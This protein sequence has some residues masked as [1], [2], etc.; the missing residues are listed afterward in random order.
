MAAPAPSAPGPHEDQGVMSPTG[1]RRAID[2]RLEGET[3]GPRYDRHPAGN[4]MPNGVLSADVVR[5]E[6]MV[7]AS[8]G[9]ASLESA[10]WPPAMT[11]RTEDVGPPGTFSCDSGLR[12]ETSSV[13]AGNVG[14]TIPHLVARASTDNHP[15]GSQGGTAL[16]VPS[17]MSR[18][19]DYLRQASGQVETLTTT[20]TRS[21]GTDDASS[22]SI[23]VELVQ[24]EVRRQVEAALA[25][26]KGRIVVYLME[27]GP[28]Q[29]RKCFMRIVVYLM[30][31][32]PTQHRKCFMR[33]VV[34]LMEIGPLSQLK[35]FMRIVAY[36]MEIGPLSQ[37]K[38][39]MRIVAYLM[40]IGPLSQLKCF[41]RIVAYLM[42]I[43]PL[44]QL[45][46]FMR[47]VAYLME[48]GPL[49]QHM[50]FVRIV[51]Y[52]MEIGPPQ[53]L[54]HFVRI[55]VYLMEIG[56][57]QHLMHFVRIVVYL[58]EIGPLSLMHLVRIVVYLMEIGPTQHLMH[59]LRIVVYLMVVNQFR[60]CLG[61]MMVLVHRGAKLVPG[62]EVQED[63]ASLG[64]GQ[65]M[66]MLVVMVPSDLP[67]RVRRQVVVEELWVRGSEQQPGDVAPAA[68]SSPSPMDIVLTGIGQL[69]QMLLKK[70]D[71]LDVDKASPNFPMLPDYTPESGAIDFQDWLYLVEQQVS[72]MAA[73]A[74]EWWKQ[75]MGSALEAYQEY[76]ALSPIKRLGVKARLSE[77]LQDGKYQKL[78]KKVAALLLAALPTGVRD[79]LV[80]YRVQGTHQILFRLMAVY[81]PGGAQDRAQLL[82]QLEVSESPGTATDA[83]VALRRWYRLYQRALD[84][85]VSLP[86]ESVQVKSLGVLTKKVAE[87]N[88]DFR[89]K[90]SLAKAELQI[91]TRPTSENVLKYFQ[92]LLAECEQLGATG[93]KATPSQASEA[94]GPKLKGMQQQPSDAGNTTQR[95]KAKASPPP[96]N[97]TKPCSWFTT[98]DGCRNGKNCSFRHSWEGLQRAERCLLCGSTKHRARDCPTKKVSP[99]DKPAPKPRLAKQQAAAATP[100]TGAAS[101]EGPS[102]SSGPS[103]PAGDATREQPSSLTPSTSNKID[104]E[105]VAAMLSETNKML[106]ALTSTQAQ[107]SGTGS[108][109]SAPSDPLGV[110]QRQLEDLRRLRMLVV[111][112]GEG[113]Q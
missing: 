111:L 36:L 53:H 70:G 81:Q 9:A 5:R 90:V 101:S 54:M 112:S 17:W 72:A 37:L 34:Y 44:S 11:S 74:G 51:V 21:V 2:S 91:D 65:G 80:A 82:K 35:C 56:P 20:L 73:S 83:V 93:R 46:C 15:G 41:M 1:A 104:T 97:P 68:P 113:W 23:P 45:K 12:Q 66:C 13:S 38:C 33:I 42:E 47:I 76:Q 28:T 78:A 77:E 107:G 57:T 32:G 59:F 58:M 69:Q 3:A 89:F 40:E 99:T 105:Q 29:H 43:G 94:P 8:P 10:P 64:T 49:S 52:L 108:A 18:L 16:P 103:V 88:Q 71:G 55:V 14:P 25:G 63:M 79:E 86:D 102:L 19:G 31:I 48:I 67:Q 26:Q 39:F 96:T 61:P 109:S 6:D 7:Q 98:D 60:R 84:L 22:A 30:E 95:P 92:H 87:T 50:H 4:A 85:G 106:K 75:V 100:T 27:I 110:I 62:Q 24:E